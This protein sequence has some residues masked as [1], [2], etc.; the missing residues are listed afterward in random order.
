LYDLIRV[1]LNLCMM[2]GLIG[3]VIESL[4]F[5]KENFTHFFCLAEVFS[6]YDM[7]IRG[8]FGDHIY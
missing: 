2:L 1:H 4:K 5:L 7:L 3:F 8:V 6:A